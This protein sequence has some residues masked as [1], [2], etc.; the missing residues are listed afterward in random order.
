MPEI[1]LHKEYDSSGESIQDLFDRTEEGFFVPL[2]QREYTWEEENINQLFD[3]LV[4]GTRELAATSSAATFLGTTILTTLGDKKESVKA[5]EERAQPTAVQIVIDGQQRISTLA[6]LSIQIIVKLRDLLEGLPSKAP[7]SDL[8]SVGEKFIERLTKLHV[9]EIG[10]RA[11]PPQKPKIIRAREDKWTYDGSDDA[12]SSPV[13]RYIATFIRTKNSEEAL[14]VL[15]AHSASRVRGNVKL[16]NAWLEKVCSAHIPGTDIYDQFPV[17]AIIT[18]ERI[19]EYVLGFTDD[20]VKSIVERVETDKTQNDYCAAAMYQLL[21][22]THYLLR[23]CGV[24]CLQPTREE[25]GFDMFQALNTTGTPLTAIETFL[26]DVMQAELGAVEKWEGT[27]SHESMEDIQKLFD[28]TDTNEEKGRRTNELLRTF[29]LCYEGERVGNKFSEQRK[30][31]KNRYG[32]DLTK[33][34]QRRDFTHKLS[35]VAKFFYY[36]WHMEDADILY[37][38]NGLK[39]HDAS[40]LASLLLQYLRRAN[41]RLSAPILARFYT[42][43]INE[44]STF[45]E[46]VESAKACAAFF[47]LWRSANSTSGLDEI[48]RKYFK[49]NNKPV[50]V[51]P[52]NWKE[53]SGPIFIQDLKKYFLD[54]LSSKKIADKELWMTA[55]EPFL[56][57]NEIREVC[58]FMLFVGSHG[59]IADPDKPGLTK[60]ANEGV[61]ELL[62]YNHWIDKS[63]KSIEHI[64]PQKPPVQ[65]DWGSEIYEGNLVH[66]IGN[67]ILLPMDINRFANN[68][69]WQEKYL[70]Y[71]HVGEEDQLKIDQ[72]RAN[73]I[74]KGIDLNRKRINTLLKAKYNCVVKPILSIKESDNWTTNLINARTQQIKGLAWKTLF[75]WLND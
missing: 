6:L 74:N 12:Y 63:Y 7:Y 40:G 65:H 24:N 36:A 57:Y 25:W 39:Q 28:A 46:F 34:H 14:D 26:P 38:V 31:I 20:G 33:I 11:N 67:L 27:P 44:E 41:S 8:H 54:V 60:P 5:G 19:Q 30:W 58:R 32:E 52:H 48:Y 56:L 37:P 10:K 43:V 2:Y 45:D 64:A 55:S 3:D 29:V 59:R 70:Y 23:C 42:Q 62:S 68:K 17:G 71:C 1:D 69:N 75:S 13:S 47:T 4:L 53:H 22:L 9:I 51:N 73:A 61:C 18:S 21:L 15:D 72:L 35:T 50:N 16:I 66:Q 49:G